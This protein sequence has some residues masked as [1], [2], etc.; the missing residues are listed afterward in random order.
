[1]RNEFTKAIKAAAFLRAN[2]HCQSC[3]DKLRPGGWECDHGVACGLN[4]SGGNRDIGNAVVLCLPCHSVKT[5]DDIKRIAKAKRIERKR[6]GL[7][8]RRGRPMPGTKASGWR[9]RMNGKWER[10]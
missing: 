1:M 8:K 4:L 5:R 10:R 2:G 6:L 7:N 3:G 9:H